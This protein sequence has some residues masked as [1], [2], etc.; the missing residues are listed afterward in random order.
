MGNLL[1]KAEMFVEYLKEFNAL[2]VCVRLFLTVFLSGAIGLERSKSG[3]TAGL[4]THMLICLGATIASMTGLY[5][6]EMYGAGDVSRIA[7]QV[8]S[9]IGFLGAGTILVKNNVTVKGLTTSACV[10]AVGTIGIAVGYGF[11]EAAIIGTILIFLVTKKLEGVDQKLKNNMKAVEVY[12]EFVSA[13][14]LQ[15]TLTLM[16]TLGLEIEEIKLM[17]TKTN[18]QD[19]IGADIMMHL[20][21][22]CDVEKMMTQINQLENVNF[23]IIVS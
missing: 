2:S 16:K 15:E 20:E 12:V 13:K 19:G 17:K 4:R 18:A 7:A 5:I 22:K 3:R 6:E 14:K 23:A 1:N 10:W 8:V 11:Y 9:G 21:K